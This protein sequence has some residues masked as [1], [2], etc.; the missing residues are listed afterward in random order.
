VQRGVVAGVLHENDAAA[1]LTH[2]DAEQAPAAAWL[3]AADSTAQL[4]QP[5]KGWWLLWRPLRTA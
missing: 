4:Q 2:A 1:L 3:L 5:G